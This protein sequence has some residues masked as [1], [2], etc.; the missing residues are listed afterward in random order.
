MIQMRK[1]LLQLNK[2][3]SDCHYSLATDYIFKL[4]T[5]MLHNH[6]DKLCPDEPAPSVS[7]LPNPSEMGQNKIRYVG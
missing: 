4:Q 5:V 1:Q 3:P 7:S 6:K 2:V